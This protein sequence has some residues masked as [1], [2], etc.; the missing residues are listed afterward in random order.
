[1]LKP[2]YF[3]TLKQFNYLCDDDA[4]KINFHG[5]SAYFASYHYLLPPTQSRVDAGL[6]GRT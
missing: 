6:Y 5:N 3:L 1:M 2:N 4:F